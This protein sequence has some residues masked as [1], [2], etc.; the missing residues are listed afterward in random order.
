MPKIKPKF[1]VREI[2]KKE[3]V[4]TNKN[5]MTIFINV[6]ETSMVLSKPVGDA[7]DWHFDNEPTKK[8]VKKW[9]QVV[10]L[11]DQ[12]IVYLEGKIK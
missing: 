4:I 1:N 3:V 12:A 6:N 7:K 11:L 10:D 5:G 2:V 8:N 9:R